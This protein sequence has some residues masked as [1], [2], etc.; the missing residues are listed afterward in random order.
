MAC[1]TFSIAPANRF[2]GVT[3]GYNAGDV[4]Q[5]P[6]ILAGILRIASLFMP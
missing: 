3:V 4:H 5:N 1:S 2:A 6:L